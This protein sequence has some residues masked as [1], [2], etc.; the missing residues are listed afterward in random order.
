MSLD[1]TVGASPR[2]DATVE[3]RIPTVE[4]P[5][6]GATPELVPTHQAQPA[7]QALPFHDDVQFTV[8]RPK[9]V[10]PGSWTSL[11]AFAHLGE[12]PPGADPREH[13]IRKVEQ[14]AREILGPAF[15]SYPKLSADSTIGLPEDAEITFVLDLPNFEV[16]QNRRTFLW[17]NAFHWEE[18]TSGRHPR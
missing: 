11:L 2:E 6:L 13:P 18:F 10:R 15:Q 3:I 1:D 5:V 9:F 8:F 17:I 12:L 7:E 14:R 4:A 16:D